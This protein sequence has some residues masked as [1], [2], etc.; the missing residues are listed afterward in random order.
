MNLDIDHPVWLLLAIVGVLSAVWGWHAMRGIPRGRRSLGVGSRALLLTTLALAMSGVYRV[1]EADDLTLIG[2]VDVSGSVQSFA[3][4]GTDELGQPINIDRAAR[5]FL[6]RSIGTREDDDRIALIAFDGNAGVVAAPSRTGVLDR[7]VTKTP[8]DGSDLPGAIA[9]ARS[10]VPP[11]SN[12][13]IVVFSDGR[14]TTPGLD[15]VPGDVQ[16][17]VVPIRYEINEEVIVESIEVPTRALP[18]AQIEARV[19]IR[20]LARSSGELRIS[21]NG[22]QIDLNGDAPGSAMRVRLEPGQRVLLVPMTLGPSRVHRFEAQYTPDEIDGAQQYSGDTS[23]QNNRAGGVTMTRSRGRVLVVSPMLEGGA[24]ESAELERVLGAEQWVVENRLPSAFPSDLLDLESFDL[25]VLVNTPRDGLPSGSDGLLS[26]YTRDLGGG[27]IFIGGHEALGAGGWQGSV[28]EEILPVKLDVADDLITPQ[29]AVV[30]VLDSSGSMRRK[31]TGSSR[32]QQQIANES[33][34]EALAILDERD[35]IGVVS[36]SNNARTVVDIGTNDRPE[37]TRSR[38]ESIGSGGG[39]NIGAGLRVAQGMLNSVEANTKHVV[40][41]SDGESMNPGEL[42]DLADAFGEQGIKVSTIAVGDD[43]DEQGMRDIARRSGGVYYRVRNPSVLPTIFLKA[44][45]VVRTPMVREGEFAPIVL[46]SQSA[47]TGTLGE[48]PTLGGLV[49]TERIGDDPRVRTPIVSSKGE[50]VLAYHQAGLGRVAV[51]TSDVGQWARNWIGDPVFA[52][53][54]GTLSAWTMRS[55][56]ESPGELTIS[57]KGSSAEIEYNAIDE[58]GAPI[59]G[60]TVKLQQYDQSGQ[61]QSIT[62]SQVGAGRYTGQTPALS[63]GVHVLIASPSDGGQALQPTI[64]GLE[65]SGSAE[66]AHLDADPQSLIALAQRSGGRVFDLGSTDAVDLFSRE[67]LTVRRSL[68]PI[69]T[70]LIA[71][72]FVL[73]LIDLAMRRVAFDHWVAQAREDTIAAAKA[74]RGEQIQQAFAT[75][76]QARA[77]APETPDIDRSPMMRA[78][79]EKKSEPE[80]KAEETKRDNP[81]LAAKRRAREQFDE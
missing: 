24:R 16:I 26:A 42:P 22:E 49:M 70:T 78:K 59:D 57:M 81:L 30:L 45:R 8:I 14:S 66:F 4:F 9:R 71:I 20:S 6:A 13:R 34:A 15:R 32:S 74:I 27:V 60:L 25:V 76:Q 28:I 31:I 3:R 55:G 44:I 67:G 12:A 54:W 73:F 65:V 29:V 56:D 33:A 19:V 21:D 38:I 48:L 79:P 68:Q 39:T 50:P 43:A 77:S 64:A 69:W 63:P 2:V 46:D 62:L 17:D 47:A 35:L 5:A 1:Q 36:F 23:L 41:L 11:G 75:R 37:D 52:Q 40:L 72:A 61:A 51:F 10:L 18:G 53:L 80:Q 58:Q 7:S